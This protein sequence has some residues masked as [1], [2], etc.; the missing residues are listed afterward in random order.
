LQDIINDDFNQKYAIKMTSARPLTILNRQAVK[1]LPMAGQFLSVD[2]LPST[3]NGLDWAVKQL[4]GQAA[5]EDGTSAWIEGMMQFIGGTY[6]LQGHVGAPDA[7]VAGTATGAAMMNENANGRMIGPIMQRI[8]ADKELMLQIL[9]NIR[10]YSAPEQRKELAKR[11]GPDVVESF[12]NCNFRQTLSISVKEN[13]DTPR[14]MALTQANIMAFGQIASGLKDVPWGLELLSTMGDVLG[15]PFEIGPGRSDRREA[16]YRLNKLAAIEARALAKN[17]SFLADTA[18]AATR[19]YE[20]MAEICAPLVDPF[21]HEHESFKDVYKDWLFGERAKTSSDAMKAVVGKLWFDHFEAQQAQQFKLAELTKKLSGE[22]NPQ[23]DEDDQAE[24]AVA[25]AALEHITEQD[26][27]DADMQ[28]EEAQKDEDLKR[29]LVEKAAEHELAQQAQQ[30]G[31][32][33]EIVR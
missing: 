18:A 9:E 2:K 8:A 16:E 24:T 23:P 19:M 4:P 22:V 12:F 13:T 27:R 28:R 11:F 25:G 30:N 7:K 6:S 33:P 31:N 3:V 20:V 29:R 26:S 17:P 14:S 15:I 1:E 32:Q 5:A 21:M 10:D